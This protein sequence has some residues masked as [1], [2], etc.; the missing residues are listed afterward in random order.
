MPFSYFRSTRWVLERHG[1]YDYY[2][3]CDT[4]ADEMH[5]EGNTFVEGIRRVDQG[6]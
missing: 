2:I 6:F 3:L 5:S 4:T 1:Y